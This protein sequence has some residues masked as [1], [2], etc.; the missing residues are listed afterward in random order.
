VD[1][2]VTRVRTVLSGLVAQQGI[3]AGHTLI[4]AEWAGD[5]EDLR[6]DGYNTVTRHSDWTIAQGWR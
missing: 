3:V 2:I 4:C 6:D 1:K 5:S